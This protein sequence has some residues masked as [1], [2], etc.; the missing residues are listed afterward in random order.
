MLF[1]NWFFFERTIFEGRPRCC[2]EY[3][4]LWLLLKCCVYVPYIMIVHCDLLFRTSS[5]QFG[6]FSPSS[7][8]IW[9]HEDSTLAVVLFFTLVESQKVQGEVFIMRRIMFDLQGCWEGHE[10]RT[11]G[12][13][14]KCTHNRSARLPLSTVIYLNCHR[15]PWP[16][17]ISRSLCRSAELP[18][19]KRPII[20]FQSV[21]YLW[22]LLYFNGVCHVMDASTGC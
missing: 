2:S 15:F 4:T 12:W 22:S 21:P 16:W 9:R 3:Y 13:I 5:P 6:F 14:L 1:R 17:W 19:W 7:T 8:D 10:T 20:F 18:P 11:R